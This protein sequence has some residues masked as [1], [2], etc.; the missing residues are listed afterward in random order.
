M[1]HILHKWWRGH[2]AALK[3]QRADLSAAALAAPDDIALQAEVAEETERLLELYKSHLTPIMVLLNVIILDPR[4]MSEYYIQAW[5][6]R[7]P[8]PPAALDGSSRPRC[9]A[10]SGGGLFDPV[11]ALCCH[12]LDPPLLS[13]NHR[14]QALDAGAHAHSVGDRP[15]RSDHQ[16]HRSYDVF[17]RRVIQRS[18]RRFPPQRVPTAR[19]IFLG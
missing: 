8:P 7:A 10:V 6:V 16:E 13:T 9:S 3:K 4:Q 18:R 1:V 17:W 14:S 12:H 15:A 2:D 19:V 11:L 5:C